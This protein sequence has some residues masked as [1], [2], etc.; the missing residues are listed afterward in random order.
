MAYNHV[1]ETT[2]A[3][4]FYSNCIELD[5]SYAPAHHHLGLIYK[6]I[7][8]LHKAEGYLKIAVKL[9]DN[10][11]YKK[12]LIAVLKNSI[13]KMEMDIKDLEYLV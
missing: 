7:D 13:L 9:G 4:L 11:R 8:D 6:S 12:D 2:Q 5:P 3:I 1:G 10:S